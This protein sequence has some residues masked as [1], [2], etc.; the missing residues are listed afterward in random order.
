M[1]SNPSLDLSFGTYTIPSPAEKPIPYLVTAFLFVILVYAVGDRAPKL[2]EVNPLKAFEFTNRRRNGEFVHQSKEIALKGK[3]VFG[4]NPFRMHTEWGEVVVLPP[5]FMQELRNDPGL[6]FSDTLVD[7]AHGY[8]PGFDPFDGNPAILTIIT[9]YLTKALAKLTKPISK[10]ATL[11]LRHVLTDSTDW[12][13]ITPRDDIIRIVSRLSSRVFMGEEICRDEEWVRVSG[14]YSGAAFVVGW[15]LSQWPRWAR[16]IVHWFLPSCWYVRRLL[17]ECRSTLKPHLERRNARKAAALARGEKDPIF[18]DSIEW[19]EKEC[20][21]N[22][23]PVR[24]QIT[25]SLVAIHTTSELLQQTMLDLASHPELFQ[26]LREELV[27]VLSAEGL[28]TTAFHNL[29][30]MDSVIKESQR[31]KPVL[32][33]TWRRFVKEDI[34][35]STG[36]VLRKGQKI[37][38]TNAHMWDSQYY[39]NPQEYDGYRFL[40][41]CGTDEE[42]LAYL[43]NTSAKHPAFGYGHHACPGRFFAANELKIALAHLLLKY[44]WKLP[45]GCN[46]QPMPYGMALMPDPSALLL[47]QRR[48]EEI[49]LDS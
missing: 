31:M 46:P 38:C 43:V 30:L 45:A 7:D 8:I 32:L 15:G 28:T 3:A 40:K 39:E 27:R 21:A 11:V 22:Y 26:P 10:E 1:E 35:L 24:E 5:A 20:T 41:M 25:M 18:D 17:A 44:D 33:S 23:D 48:K 14:F 36:F 37:I 4:D 12:H 2:P 9:K 13:Q 47:I 42:K 29:K 6:E 49:D 19:F 16:P 34:E